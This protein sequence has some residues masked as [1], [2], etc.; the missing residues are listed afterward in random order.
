MITTAAPKRS[1]NVKKRRNKKSP[2]TATLGKKTKS[3]MISKRSKS[4]RSWK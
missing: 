1:S 4:R 2:P 3:R